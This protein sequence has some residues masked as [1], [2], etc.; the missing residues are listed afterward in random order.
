[1][2]AARVP[3]IRDS[4]TPDRLISGVLDAI[5]EQAAVLDPRGVVVRANLAW[6]QTPTEHRGIVD[7][8]NPGTDHIATLRAQ[9]TRVARIAADGILSVLQGDLPGFQTDY[10]AGERAY[11]M[12]VD[13]LPGGGAVVRHVDITFRQ[14]LQR[15]LAH[16][17]THDPLTGLP[18][19]MVMA[20]RLGQ[21]LIRATR[22]GTPVGVLFCDVDRF[23]QINDTQGHAV[24]DQVLA[25]IGRR[26]HNAVQ[27]SDLVARFGGD[28]FVILIEDATDIEQIARQLQTA[29]T[30]PIVVD[31]R[32]LHFGVS[33]GIAVHSGTAYPRS[34]DR[35]LVARR[36][37]RRHVRSEIVR[38]RQHLLLSNRRCAPRCGIP[39]SSLRRCVWQLTRTRS[40]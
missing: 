4:T 29:A 16:R 39:N 34:R 2:E 6:L 21:A 23:K 25:A 9:S 24:G 32:P 19:R 38:A 22:T 15:Q 17:A 18:N 28:E 12:Q 20:E 30:S 36:C 14:H 5:S 11:G 10:D 33:L 27:Q 37:R 7:R 8:S 31:G 3:V 13:P 35:R 40:G 26:L 1:M